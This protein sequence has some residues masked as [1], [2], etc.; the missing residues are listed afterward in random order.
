[1]RVVEARCCGFD[2]SEICWS[3]RS[4]G[5]HGAWDGFVGPKEAL[6]FI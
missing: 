4:I 5:W 2:S 1:M 3:Q 6:C